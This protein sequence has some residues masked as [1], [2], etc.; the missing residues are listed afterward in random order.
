M[1]SVGTRTPGPERVGRSSL[2]GLLE[3]GSIF[4]SFLAW[5]DLAFLRSIGP[6]DRFPVFPLTVPFWGLHRIPRLPCSPHLPSPPSSLK[7]R[8]QTLPTVQVFAVPPLSP[9]PQGSY[10]V[11]GT[12]HK[13]LFGV[14]GTCLTALTPSAPL[15]L[16]TPAAVCL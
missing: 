16:T 8:P 7:P 14:P 2:F 13:G 1:S 3:S 5:R 4:Q 9:M 12:S 6:T 11:C 15:Y 10:R